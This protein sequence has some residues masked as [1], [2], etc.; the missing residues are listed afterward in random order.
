M[1]LSAPGSKIPTYGTEPMLQTL[2]RN[3]RKF[4]LPYHNQI[5]ANCQ[6]VTSQ[7]KHY[8][9]NMCRSFTDHTSD[10]KHKPRSTSTVSSNVPYT[11]CFKILN[12]H[13]SVSC[14][15]TSTVCGMVYIAQF[16]LL[17]AG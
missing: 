15:A 9:Y 11:S 8:I 5:N 6:C 7:I 3:N 13:I 10:N 14:R 4:K 16:I 2:L 17:Y 12:L 1:R